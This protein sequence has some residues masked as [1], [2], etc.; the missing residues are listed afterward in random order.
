MT[1]GTLTFAMQQVVARKST[2][3]ELGAVCGVAGVMALAGQVRIPLPFTPVPLTL[4]TMLVLL[5]GIVLGARAGA[6]GQVLYVGLG[7]MGQ[8]AAAMLQVPA[9]TV[10]LIGAC[11]VRSMNPSICNGDPSI[12]HSVCV[13]EEAVAVAAA[14]GEVLLSQRYGG[15]SVLRGAPADP[16]AAAQVVPPSPISD[17]AEALVEGGLDPAMAARIESIRSTL[18]I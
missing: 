7:A 8:R 15:R 1:Q 2:W 12:V 11:S 10:S 18:C 14:L 6:L 3:V 16:E 4:Q 13:T 9:T 17:G 5:S